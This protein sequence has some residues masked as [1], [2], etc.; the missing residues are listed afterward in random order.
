MGFVPHWQL[1]AGLVGPLVNG[2]VNGSCCQLSKR[3]RERPRGRDRYLSK[4]RF[5][6]H[7]RAAA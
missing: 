5:V 4:M 7:A 6:S 1:E 3:K 2:L